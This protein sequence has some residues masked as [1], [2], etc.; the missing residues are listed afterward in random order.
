MQ[1]VAWTEREIEKLVV[2]V[3]SHILEFF[4]M[5]EIKTLHHRCGGGSVSFSTALKR[6]AKS[7][8]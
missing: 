1:S 7:S 2:H 6:E 3:T 4:C 8:S 5:E